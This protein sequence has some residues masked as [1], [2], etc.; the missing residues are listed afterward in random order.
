MKL[1][2]CLQKGVIFEG[3]RGNVCKFSRHFHQHGLIK[4]LQRKQVLFDSYISK[5]TVY[6]PE[7]YAYGTAF[8]LELV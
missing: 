4:I 5:T 6:E 1:L 2:I 3:K 7:R 8:G